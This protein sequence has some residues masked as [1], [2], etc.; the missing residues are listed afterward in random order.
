MSGSQRSDY[1]QAVRHALG[2]HASARTR[3]KV[4][5][6]LLVLLIALVALPPALL[7][8]S[9]TFTRAVQAVDATLGE[10]TKLETEDLE[11][12]ITAAQDALAALRDQVQGSAVPTTQ[13]A[14]IAALADATSELE[15]L[16]GSAL[17]VRLDLANERRTL[18]AVLEDR[19]WELRREHGSMLGGSYG[20]R[21]RAHVAALGAWLTPYGLL[22]WLAFVYAI[23][24]IPPSQLLK[25]FA[26]LTDRLRGLWI[27]G[28]RLE[29]SEKLIRSDKME[30]QYAA[31]LMSSMIQGHYLR[32][33]THHS[34]DALFADLIKAVINEVSS[35]LGELDRN[36]FRATLHVPYYFGREEL[37]QFVNYYDRQG[38]QQTNTPGRGRVYSIRYGIIGR[39]WREGRPRY[40]PAVTTDRNRLVKEWGLTQSEAA[41]AGSGRQTM[42]A[43]RLHDSANQPIGVV[44]M[45]AK[46]DMIF[47]TP[48]VRAD[49][50]AN[51]GQNP[52]DEGRYVSYRNIDSETNLERAQE[53]EQLVS[54][55][56]A[57]LVDALIKVR[58][59]VGWNDE[60]RIFI[61]SR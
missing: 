8:G 18:A 2:Y 55:K 21:L 35:D 20:E 6:G 1:E 48:Q 34:V 52:T 57:A 46:Q 54:D 61:G 4:G 3:W 41:Q 9:E 58:A 36:N 13:P 44:Y 51:G 22:A 27:M 56:A 23:L 31:Q 45:D 40:D 59:E 39:A 16:L 38:R 47:S 14:D 33:G 60:G 7:T 11:I 12:R 32:A 29:L 53:L 28:L 5:G 19:L 42:L 15:A 26:S 24:F 43:L 50:A 30:M 49:D 37:F 17:Q 10:L 25:P